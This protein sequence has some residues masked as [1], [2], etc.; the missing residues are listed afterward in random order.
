[1]DSLKRAILLCVLLLFPSGLLF[2]NQPDI[3]NHFNFPDSILQQSE[4]AQ[5]GYILDSAEKLINIDYTQSRELI[6]LARQ[7]ADS[8]KDEWQLVKALFLQGKLNYA[9]GDFY[10]AEEIFQYLLDQHKDLLDN[11]TLAEIKHALGLTYMRFNNYNKAINLIQ[12]ALFSYE[13][14]ED[15]LNIATATKD[16]GVIYYYL[17]NENSALEQYQKA[18]MLYR[19]IGNDQGIAQCLNNIGM[20][21]RLKGNYALAIEYLEKSLEIKYYLENEPGIANG[22][23]NIGHVYASAGDF[24]KAIDYYNQML[25]KW[26][27]MDNLN[28]ISEAYNYLGEVYLRMEQPKKAIA[29]LRKGNQIASE[30]KLKQRLIDNYELLTEAYEKDGNYKEALAFFKKYNLSKDSLYE[31]LTNQ[32]ISEYIARYEKLRAENELIDQERKILKQRFQIII[33]LIILVALM[34]FL[35][36]LYRQ[37]RTIRRK[38]K[39]IQKINQELDFRVQ[40]KTSELRLA[41]FSIDLAFDAIIWIHKDGKIIYVNQ[42]ACNMLFYSKKELEG[43]YIFDIVAEFTHEVWDDYWDQ[44]KQKESLV[45]QLNYQTKKGSEIP[46]EVVFNFREFEGREYNFTFSRNIVERKVAEEKLK[47]AKEKAER[48]DQ[49]KSAFLANMSHEIRTPMN[50]INGFLS[51]LT[52][53]DLTQE[54]RQEI[55]ELART[56]S[57]DLLHIINDII[58]ISKIEADEL[59]IEKAL[60]Y[61]NGILQEIYDYYLKDLGYLHKKKV[62]LKLQIDDPDSM[63]QLAV[64]TDRSRF[65]QIMHNLISNAIKFTDEGEI[66]FGYQRIASGGRKLLKFF[67]KDTGIGIPEESQE[68]IF[69]RYSKLDDQRKKVYKGTGL[70]LAISKKLVHMLGGKIGVQSEIDKGSEFYFTLPYKVLDSGEKKLF[71][72]PAKSM[73]V[74]WKDKVILVVEDT[75]SNYLLL[76]NYLKSTNV[77]IFWAKSGKEALEIFNETEHFDLV[78][79]DIQLPG[80]N[81]Y[82]VTKLMKA[83]NKNIPVIAQTAHALSGEKELSLREGCDDYIAKPFK[84]DALIELLS[85]HLQE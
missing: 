12:E 32:R 34:V 78:L 13:Q 9:N 29:V 71:Y 51:L 58:D 10:E 42:S 85:K 55:T 47:K 36:I 15:R 80:I 69:N 81:G 24:E 67:V 48:S 31:N 22:L 38:S 28:G 53:S 76:E 60:Y 21:F 39:K 68:Y 84:K 35:F 30:N 40:Q 26:L 8:L 56:S 7:Y 45:I 27:E 75:P 52:D 16:I 77:Q 44:I 17:G 62:E 19:K 6:T 64:Y 41:R 37:N 57:N 43:M 11:H 46:V 33:T 73:N 65:K 3:H 66:V 63:N 50:A 82:E 1:M 70:G 2:G 74:D 23:G 20:I 54:Q 18:L 14:T 83:H 61:V 79:M 25:G 49:Q 4:Q 72:T 5:I 59:T